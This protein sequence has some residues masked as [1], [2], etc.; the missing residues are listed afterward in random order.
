MKDKPLEFVNKDQPVTDMLLALHLLVVESIKGGAKWGLLET[1]GKQT[2]I[3]RVIE[4]KKKRVEILVLL[5]ERLVMEMVVASYLDYPQW[6]RGYCG[7][8]LSKVGWGAYEALSLE[9]ATRLLEEKFQKME[10]D[11]YKKK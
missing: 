2:Y 7:K 1:L 11:L 6:I 3:R 8:G 9:E 5:D 4:N 10:E